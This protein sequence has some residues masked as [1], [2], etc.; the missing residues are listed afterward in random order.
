MCLGEKMG[1]IEDLKPEIEFDSGRVL[2][3]KCIC[4]VWIDSPPV[5]KVFECP[6][7]SSKWKIKNNILEHK[8]DVV[9]AIK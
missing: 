8:I 4:G 2:A 9:E 7:C 3:F 6:Y 5:N 1:K